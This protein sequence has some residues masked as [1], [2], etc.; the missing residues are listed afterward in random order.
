MYDVRD[1]RIY[2]VG[3]PCQPAYTVP[4]PILLL[5]GS[6]SHFF[7]SPM[8]QSPATKHSPPSSPPRTGSRKRPQPNPGEIMQL[9]KLSFIAL[10]EANWGGSGI[11]SRCL[12]GAFYWRV[13]GHVQPVGD[14]EIHPEHTGEIIYCFSSGLGMPQDGAGKH[15]WEK[16]H[17]DYLVE[18]AVA[19]IWFQISSRN[20]TVFSLLFP[21]K[22]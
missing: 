15:C 9:W 3:L 13:S 16:E 12:V 20:W 18:P 7:Q 21:S 2:V 1:H 14:P 11:S 17:L 22:N 8:S 4:D 10:T 5:S 6:P 19:V